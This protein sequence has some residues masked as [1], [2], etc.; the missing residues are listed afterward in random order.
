MALIGMVWLSR[1][2]V[3]TSFFPSIVLPMAL[4]GLG[5]GSAL[6]PLTTAGIAGVAPDDAGAASGLVNVAQQLGGSLGLGILVTVFAAAS[7]ALVPPAVAGLPV[8]TAAQQE[9]AH[10]VATSLTGSAI[11]LALG[12]F[13]VA[14]VMRRPVTGVEPG[15]RTV[16]VTD[17]PVA[18]EL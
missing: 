18:A 4:L 2:T 15:D 7:H 5:I 16:T 11:F 13:V 9:L 6:V 3:D 1:L 8:R 17:E 10:A 14:A 12:L